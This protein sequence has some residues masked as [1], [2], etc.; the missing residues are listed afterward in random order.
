MGKM[1][2]SIFVVGDEVFF[3]SKDIVKVEKCDTSISKKGLK[4]WYSN[5]GDRENKKTIRR[6]TYLVGEEIPD[7]ES[8]IFKEDYD[9]SSVSDGLKIWYL[10]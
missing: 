6:G 8:I 1:H 4:I 9:T 5:S 10:D 7:Q 3:S 2:S